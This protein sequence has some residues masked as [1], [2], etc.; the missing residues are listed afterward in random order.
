MQRLRPIGTDAPGSLWSILL[1]HRS[2]SAGTENLSP[3]FGDRAREVRVPNGAV[4]DA[5]ERQLTDDQLVHH[6][7]ECVE[8]GPWTLVAPCS[9]EAL[10][11]HVER[12]A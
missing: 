5:K 12:S 6:A 9:N 8:V 2:S 11:R 10:R 7:P 1:V 4:R 3:K